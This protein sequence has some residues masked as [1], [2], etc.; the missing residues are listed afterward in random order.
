MERD[1]GGEAGRH[2]W[3]HGWEGISRDVVGMRL[4]AAVS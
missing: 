1:E 3:V 4:E 2:G